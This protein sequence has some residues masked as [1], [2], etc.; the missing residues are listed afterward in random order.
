MVWRKVWARNWAAVKYCS[1]ACRSRP[2]NARD[3][4]L[5]D[6]ILQLLQGRPGGHSLCP[7]EAARQVWGDTLGLQRDNMERTRCAARRLV[8]G[9]RLQI[10]QR[11]QVVEPDHARGPIRL[12]LTRRPQTGDLR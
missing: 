10:T 5:E 4:E 9:G 7:S 3:Q 1:R 8:A 2:P 6:C 12:R 11:G